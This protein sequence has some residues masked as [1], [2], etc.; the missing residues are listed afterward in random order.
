M[1]RYRWKSGSDVLSSDV[2]KSSIEDPE[3][4]ELAEGWRSREDEEGGAGSTEV[5]T[6]K[7]IRR[8]AAISLWMGLTG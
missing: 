2:L 6:L 1:A 3:L 4:D 5:Y 7:L 8:C